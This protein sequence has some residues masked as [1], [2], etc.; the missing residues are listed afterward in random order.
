ME[1]GEDNSKNDAKNAEEILD[2]LESGPK[3]DHVKKRQ[4]KQLRAIFIGLGV[5]IALIA[6]FPF[7]I[8][9]SNSFEYE[10]VDFKIVQEGELTFYNTKVPLYSNG[11]YYNDY[12]FYLRNDPRKLNVKF[13]GALIFN[14][15]MVISAEDPFSCGG[16]EIIAIENLKRLYQLYDRK[17]I[18]N[19]SLGCDILGRYT[20]INLKSG[21]ET[22][23]ELIGPA[24]YNII[25]NDCEIL[26][27][28][29]KFMIETFVKMNKQLEQQ[30]L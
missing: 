20:H 27:G 28:T 4:N 10:G 2:E 29:E 15:E 16:Y 19:E 26:E 22:K 14:K 21:D 17:V 12:N 5:F 9:S 24:C 23:I 18:K 1:H 6:A 3:E 11:E 30:Q 7:F 13:T 25:I 8:N